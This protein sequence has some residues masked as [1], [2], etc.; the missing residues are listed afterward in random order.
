MNLKKSF[1]N[2]KKI[3]ISFIFAL[4]FQGYSYGDIFYQL[5]IGYSEGN[6][7]SSN[8]IGGPYAGNI[9][10]YK[11]D[12]GVGL[13]SKFL[14]L[15]VDYIL[16]YSPIRNKVKAKNFCSNNSFTCGLNFKDNLELGAKFFLPI[17][18]NETIPAIYIGVANAD[19]ELK[20]NTRSGG[21]ATSLYSSHDR[22]W[23]KTIGA[24][25]NRKLQT[26][27]FD[28]SLDYTW[29]TFEKYRAKTEVGGGGEEI[30][31]AKPEIHL[32]SLKLKKYF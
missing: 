3:I 30:T 10:G 31:T 21:A 27:N 18:Y 2:F 15:N 19:I 1:I 28:V 11:T 23:G 26:F 13:T 25:V 8:S 24:S 4:V 9:E 5:G 17:S 14:D 32:F 12:I 22:I 16:Q 7:Q 20:T 29:T 6:S